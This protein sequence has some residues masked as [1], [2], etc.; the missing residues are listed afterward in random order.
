M[1]IYFHFIFF[2]VLPLV[3]MATADDVSAQKLLVDGNNQFT[4]KLFRVSKQISIN[5][6]RSAMGRPLL[7]IGRPMN[8]RLER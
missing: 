2:P 7:N 6:N 3:A 4:A 5:I 1:Y 8:A